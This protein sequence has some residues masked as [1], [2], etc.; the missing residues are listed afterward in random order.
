[1]YETKETD[2]IKKKGGRKERKIKRNKQRNVGSKETRRK[3]RTI[4]KEREKK[5]LKLKG[6]KR[7]KEKTWKEDMIVH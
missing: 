1:M 7:Q 5:K 6:R 3:R 2:E 4:V